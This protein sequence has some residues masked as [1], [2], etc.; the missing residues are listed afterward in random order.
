MDI[1]KLRERAFILR[2]KGEKDL[3]W[4]P[5]ALVWVQAGET[6]KRNLFSQ[7]GV[8]KSG[9]EFLM[10]A[11][12]LTMNDA[13]LWRGQ[14]FFISEIQQTGLYP[15]YLKVSC[16]R[17]TPEIA[18]I[19]RKTTVMGTLGRP[20]ETL[21]PVGSGP[22][23]LTEKYLGDT[24]EDSHLEQRKRLVAVAPKAFCCEAGDIMNVLGENYRVMACHT[25]EDHK[26]EYEIERVK[27]D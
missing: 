13:I 10:R 3:R 2:L 22:V 16:A 9:A 21:S 20:V 4:Q 7:V 6:G 5:E 14:H 8:G 1:G 11:A 26:N 12:D 27:D 25:L 17:V 23:C 15:R 18:G 19:S 24:A